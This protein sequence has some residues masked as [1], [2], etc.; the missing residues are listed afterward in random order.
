MLP[1]LKH[2]LVRDP[3]WFEMASATLL[4]VWAAVLLSPY[5]TF[6]ADRTYWTLE[7]FMSEWTWGLIA[8]AAAIAGLVGL[9]ISWTGLRA[10]SMLWAVFFWGS[11]G[12]C[13][14]V[15]NPLST[16]GWVYLALAALS[17][18]AYVTIRGERWMS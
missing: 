11:V 17:G 6:E 12:G 13:F 15:S 7:A 8:A 3:S 2:F 14:V 5:D 1:R 18:L 4:L 10:M 9:L 16:I